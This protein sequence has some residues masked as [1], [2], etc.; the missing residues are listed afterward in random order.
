MQYVSKKVEYTVN[1]LHIFAII[2]ILIDEMVKELKSGKSIN[3][4]GF[5]TF[6][7]NNLKPKKIRS[8]YSNKIKFAQKT[9]ALRFKLSKDLEKYLVEKTIKDMKDM[10]EKCEEK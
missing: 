1:K 10:V 3:I 4:E 7:I 2:N 5:G 8:V 9:K 6:C